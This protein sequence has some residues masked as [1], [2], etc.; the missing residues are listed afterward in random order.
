MIAVRS[1]MKSGQ[2][3]D[4]QRYIITN[5]KCAKFSR[6]DCGHDR[7]IKIMLSL[8]RIKTSYHRRGKL[9]FLPQAYIHAGCSMIAVKNNSIIIP[10]LRQYDK[11]RFKFIIM[12]KKSDNCH[13]F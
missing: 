9:I 5:N 7:V 6:R 4:C 13:I 3:S 12:V 11:T 10:A 2:I 8:S 1:D